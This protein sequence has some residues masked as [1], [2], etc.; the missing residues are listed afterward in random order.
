MHHPLWNPQKPRHVFVTVTG[1]LLNMNSG[2][3]EPY[4]ERECR[5]CWKREATCAPEE[6]CPGSP[7]RPP[8]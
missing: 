4:T 3:L 5:I 2:S 8:R 6:S 7:P 1:N